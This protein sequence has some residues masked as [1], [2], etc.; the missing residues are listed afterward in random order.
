MQFSEEFIKYDG[1]SFQQATLLDYD[2]GKPVSLQNPM[3]NWLGY[4]NYS[5]T[6]F[7]VLLT[8]HRS[9]YLMHTHMPSALFVCVSWISFVVPVEAIPGRITLLVTLLL[10]LINIFNTSVDHQPLSD[11]ITAGSGN[12]KNNPS[13]FHF[14]Y[15]LSFQL[16]SSRAFILYLVHSWLT[17]D[18]STSSFGE[19]MWIALKLL[20]RN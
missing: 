6:G 12:M 10:V 20:P 7:E 1:D 11:T 2:I 19:L 3:Y 14:N 16:G 5:L 4:G 15:E 13:Q 8:R 18:Y 17:Q 9:R